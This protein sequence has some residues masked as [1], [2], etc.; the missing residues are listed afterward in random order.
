MYARGCCSCRNHCRRRW[1]RS[2][3]SVPR[4]SGSPPAVP[5]PAGTSGPAPRPRP[6]RRVRPQFGE[7]SPRIRES[8]ASRPLRAPERTLSDAHRRTPRSILALGKTTD[9]VAAVCTLCLVGAVV[10]WEY[11]PTESN[12]GEGET[13]ADPQGEILTLDPI[14]VYLKAV[15]R[16]AYP[17][18]RRVRFQVSSGGNLAFPP[19]RVGPL[20]SSEHKHETKSQAAC[21][22]HQSEAETRPE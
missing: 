8:G 18:R 11:W 21:A 16:T 9:Y 22:H 17:W 5:M 14:P 15:K 3:A 13:T 2:V 6:G 4:C 10:M 20:D 1:R 12:A 19:L 7:P